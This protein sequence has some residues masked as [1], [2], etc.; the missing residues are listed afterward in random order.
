MNSMKMAVL[1]AVLG[2]CALFLSAGLLTYQ[3]VWNDGSIEQ[4]PNSERCASFTANAISLL[5]LQGKITAR[6]FEM[7]LIETRAPEKLIGMIIE[8]HM[9]PE[10]M[11]PI[12]QEFGEMIRIT[13][14]S[15]FINAGCNSTE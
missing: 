12:H 6:R 4:Q 10:Y 14:D 3:S 9:T 13:I 5:N 8:R 2:V 11:Q 15:L 1:I 7:A